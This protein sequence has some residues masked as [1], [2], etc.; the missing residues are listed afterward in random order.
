MQNLCSEVSQL[1]SLLEVQLVNGLGAIN[2][3]WVVV[4]HTVDIGPNLNLIGSDSSSDERSGI[5]ATSTLQV[6]DLAVSIAA[7]ETLSEINLC[8][9]VLLHKSSKFLL[10]V[11][12]IGLGIL[13]GTHKVESVE[14]N[15]LDADLVHVVNHHVGRDNLALSH[16]ALLLERSKELLGER[17]QVVELALQ[18]LACSGL[19]LGF[20]VQLVNVLV[21]LLLQAVD[22]LVS[23][24]GVLLIE[25]V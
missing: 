1:G 18:E 12:R 23:A 3:A 2:H 9:L 20:G 19:G 17:T 21:V 16:D 10:D 25:I 6:V 22:N 15:G 8:S 4:V 11:N 5:V 13:I 24:I 7:D 14:Q